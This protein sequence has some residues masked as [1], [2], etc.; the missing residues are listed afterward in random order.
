MLSKRWI[1]CAAAL[2]MLV[3]SVPLVWA[4]DAAKPAAPA[5]AAAAGPKDL[6]EAIPDEAWGFVAIP[7]LK[8]FDGKLGDLAEKLNF[9]IGSPIALAMGQLGIG[10]G[11]R[12]DGGV[13][14]VVLDP[15]QYGAPPDM[16]AVLIPTTD[17][18]ALLS[19]FNPQ[20]GGDGVQ[21]IEIMGKSLV[22]APKGGFVV[23][24]TE[25]N[26]VKFVADAKKGIRGSMKPELIERYGKADLYAMVNLR[27]A[28]E[29]AKPLAGQFVAMFMMNS[30]EGDPEAAE[31]IQKTAQDVVNLLDE[32]TT[33]E[34]AA[35][36]DEV[37]LQLSFYLS[38]ND[39]NI[40]KKIGTLKTTPS[41]LLTGLP[42][43]LYMLVVG[44]QG[45]ETP[46]DD[47]IQQGIM[48]L[49]L[50]RPEVSK[51]F[52]KAKMTELMK[53]LKPVQAAARDRAIS[54]SM[55]PEG[56]D[57]ML[58]VTMVTQTTDAKAT[59][60]AVQKVMDGLKGTVKDEKAKKILEA[61]TFKAGAEKVGDVAVDQ[62]V[63]DVAKIVAGAAGDAAPTSMPAWVGKLVGKEGLVVRIAPAGDKAVVCTMGGGLKRFEEVH[64]LAASNACPLSE[65]AGIT[66]ARKKLPKNRMFELYVGAD[67]ILK[68]VKAVTGSDQIPVMPDINAPLA[69]SLSAEKNFGRLDI[70]LPTELIVEIKNIVLQVMMGGGFGGG[71]T[72]SPSF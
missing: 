68:A 5:T 35:G 62:V 66:K 64:K 44:V 49:A 23:I 9:P 47:A 60:Q 50:S 43:D 63:I 21:K 70:V 26:S 72:P 57:G 42:K 32:I 13:G 46:G 29:M 38:F 61:V 10:E 7:N 36:L 52:D 19:A 31:R 2:A 16:L 59:V 56:S 41:A 12:E 15:T 39:G 22:V 37:G 1:L 54:I 53:Q 8:K 17:A 34:I 58:G 18:K 6:L 30:M 33:L 67:R 51:F 14:L 55:L 28:I 24:G 27:P 71:G 20:D 3:T 25:K 4:E 40:A 65:D 69:I 48:D 45:S 11:L